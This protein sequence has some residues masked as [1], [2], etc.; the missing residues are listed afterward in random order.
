M[1][2]MRK[3]GDPDDLDLRGRV[4]TGSSMPVPSSIAGCDTDPAARQPRTPVDRAVTTS[5]RLSEGLAKA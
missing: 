5:S 1:I 4:R 3:R 2:K